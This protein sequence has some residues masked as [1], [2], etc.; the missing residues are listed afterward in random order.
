MPVDRPADIAPIVARL[1][2]V[3]VVGCLTLPVGAFL[4]VTLAFGGT[5]VAAA[6]LLATLAGAGGLIFLAGTGTGTTRRFWWAVTVTLGGA[7]GLIG[8]ARVTVALDMRYG[9]M[10]PWALAAGVPYVLVA[11]LFVGRWTRLAAVVAIVALTGG[12]WH[13]VR[14]QTRHDDA[15]DDRN[16]VLRMLQ[17]P[18]DLVWTTQIPGY[19]RMTVPVTTSTAYEATDHTTVRYWGHQ[20]IQVALTHTAVQGADCGPDP[21]HRPLPEPNRAPPPQPRPDQISCQDRGGGLRYRRGPDAHEYIRTVGDTVVRAG[22][23]TEV[24]EALLEQAVRA[25]RPMTVEE[26]ET[27]LFYR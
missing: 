18:L 17:A 1:A 12:A 8:G 11:A 6:G 23:G 21:L 25:A 3:Y 24:D 2:A 10:L 20:N 4:F 15:E 27:E 14:E 7:A 5:A 22:A 16:R 19:R 26:L 9:E 13:A